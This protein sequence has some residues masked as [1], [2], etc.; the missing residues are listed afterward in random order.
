MSL[1]F[2]STSDNMTQGKLRQQQKQKQTGLL[3]RKALGLGSGTTR[4]FGALNQGAG[5][6]P[7]GAAAL[8]GYD[9]P[10]SPETESLTQG[11]NR[12]AQKNYANNPANP[13]RSRQEST[14]GALGLRSNDQLR[15]EGQGEANSLADALTNQNGRRNGYG[16]NERAA[17]SPHPWQPDVG[18]LGYTPPA[19]AFV[20]NEAG[21]ADLRAAITARPP[22]AER[23][24]DDAGY[25]QPQYRQ[26]T[27]DQKMID[28]PAYAKSVAEHRAKNDALLHP[29]YKSMA[30]RLG[31]VQQ[32]AQYRAGER[33][34]IS[35][36][37]VDRANAL[38]SIGTGE[39]GNLTEAQMTAAGYSEEA[40]AA[41][42]ER[43]SAALAAKLGSEEAALDRGS[44]EKTQE[45]V[46]AAGI[47]GEEIAAGG[48][49]DAAGIRSKSEDLRTAAQTA[50]AERRL[51]WEK[52]EAPRIREQEI[53]VETLKKQGKNEEAHL[54]AMSIYDD[55]LR[56]W[57][58]D[59]G[60]FRNTNNEIDNPEIRAANE[61]QYL[62]HHPKPTEPVL[63]KP[64]PAPI[65]PPT[66]TDPT[67]ARASN[68]MSNS[69]S[70]RAAALGIGATSDVPENVIV[71]EEPWDWGTYAGI[72]T[73][74]LAG[75]L[76][77][78]KFSPPPKTAAEA[79]GAGYGRLR[80]VLRGGAN[81]ASK[82]VPPAVPT[83]SAGTAASK[84][85]PP[86]V[87]TGSAGTA[88]S[89]NPRGFPSTTTSTLE[90]N[91]GPSF[92][93][94]TV[95]PSGKP[96][97]RSGKSLRKA[98]KTLQKVLLGTGE[99]TVGAAIPQVERGLAGAV[100][101]KGLSTGAKLA[102]GGLAGLLSLPAQAAMG[103]SA[104][105]PLG[106]AEYRPPEQ[107]PTAEDDRMI[108]SESNHIEQTTGFKRFPGMTP[109]EHVRI[110]KNMKAGTSPNRSATMRT[111]D[112]L[113][114]TGQEEQEG[115]GAN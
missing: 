112:L 86:A 47:K 14:F 80:S 39:E 38:R 100:T 68:S 96:R 20:P 18:G 19:P 55:K 43:Q 76:A 98:E 50:D 23:Q 73:A 54:I 27:I 105:A 106:D 45:G 82:S 35:P 79:A 36:E 89:V 85:V 25:I 72:G 83:G 77:W 59:L 3:K 65:A 70:N 91:L 103:A 110:Y 5:L 32:N 22:V 95:N 113:G 62:N 111:M 8:G 29:E 74:G 61:K 60:S 67:I 109:R 115:Y 53:K 16:A 92:S 97:V 104:A 48:L 4:P 90:P 30:E 87:P 66:S 71:P 49:T 102:V 58:A 108:L 9:L 28:D 81:A 10:V 7:G 46:N 93:G 57:T 37:Q 88:G 94:D 2:P 13:V 101:K 63:T 6:S 11:Y 33:R 21:A 75:K 64:A 56:N 114:L 12:D 84:S 42:R 41:E 69:T 31:L 99:E 107:L 17:M 24:P 40:K 52:E 15:A 26:A 51:K 44:N 1:I 34:G 78:D